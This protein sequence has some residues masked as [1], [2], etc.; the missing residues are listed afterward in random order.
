MF[1]KFALFNSVSCADVLTIDY[2]RTRLITKDSNESKQDVTIS[3]HMYMTL[4][5]KYFVIRGMLYT[6][7]RQDVAHIV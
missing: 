5:R 6:K 3:I 2:V 1:A 4:L 7:S